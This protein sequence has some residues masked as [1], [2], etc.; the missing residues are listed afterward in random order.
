MDPDLRVLTDCKH[1]VKVYPG[2]LAHAGAPAAAAA[3]AGSSEAEP[4]PLRLL[5]TVSLEPRPDH[6][7]VKAERLKRLRLRP[8]QLHTLPP[9]VVLVSPDATVAQLKTAVQQALA[10]TYRMLRGLTIGPQHRLTGLDRASAASGKLGSLAAGHELALS[11]AGGG[12]AE[13]SGISAERAWR[14][15]GGLEDWDVLCGCGTQDDDGERMICCDACSVWMH[16]RC[17]GIPDA[18]TEPKQFVCPWCLGQRQ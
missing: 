14:H 8:R 1:F 7:A 10:S 9:E 11:L 4:P 13:A 5:V 15:A 17:N 6:T 3:A 16:T 12:A 18:A 2:P